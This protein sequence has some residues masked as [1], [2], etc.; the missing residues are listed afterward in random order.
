MVVII[1]RNS[2]IC[3]FALVPQLGATGA[4]GD[5]LPV[6]LG[7]RS[8]SSCC[9]LAKGQTLPQSASRCN[10]TLMYLYFCNVFWPKTV[11]KVR[12]SEETK[13]INFCVVTFVLAFCSMGQTIL[14][15]G[16]SGPKVSEIQKGWGKTSFHPPSFPFSFSDTQK[17]RC[18]ET[19]VS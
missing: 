7:K 3:A 16:G 1:L 13:S 15:Q 17:Q 14:C 11:G 6:I 19:L 10:A 12:F 5:A 18:Q 8:F 9:H 2:Q 4:P